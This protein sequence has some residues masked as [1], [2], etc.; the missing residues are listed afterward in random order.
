[1]GI[2]ASRF[3]NNVGDKVRPIELKV[4]KVLTPNLEYTGDGYANDTYLEENEEALMKDL[5]EHTSG[6]L[7]YATPTKCLI[8]RITCSPSSS[9]V[10]GILEYESFKDHLSWEV[11]FLLKNILE[12]SNLTNKCLRVLF[13]NNPSKFLLSVN[14]VQHNTIRCVHYWQLRHQIL[15]PVVEEGNVNTYVVR[16][17][18]TMIDK[19]QCHH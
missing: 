13:L 19:H 1:M 14:I 15:A 4:S 12:D 16:I 5:T 3:T 6:N 2:H 18:I 7:V 8:R 9:N 17:C 11:T 10:F